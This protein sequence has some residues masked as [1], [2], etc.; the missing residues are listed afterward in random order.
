MPRANRRQFLSGSV[1][2]WATL[3]ASN[4]SAMQQAGVKQT[5]RA[6][7]ATSNITPF[8]GS[9]LAGNMTD[10]KAA[11]VH[12]EL[13]VRSLVLDDGANILAIAVADC[14]VMPRDIADAA[15][16][17]IQ[18]RTGI[19]AAHVL[20][21]AT[22]THSAP[23]T[24][25]LFQSIP[26]PA[27]TAWLTVRIADSVQLAHTRRRPAQIGWG[28]GKEDRL[29]F[30]RRYFMK[31]GTEWRDPFGRIDRVKTN[32]GAGNPDVV[33]PAGPT[34]PDVAVL[35]VE[36]L[37][38][39]PI[40]VLAS[41]ALHY[42]G[43]VGPRHVSADYFAMWGKS[44]ARLI[45]SGRPGVPLDG[46]VPIL[47]NACSGDVNN[48]DVL[49]PKRPKLPPYEHM[50][51]V[52]DALAAESY[53][54]WSG[55]QWTNWAPLRAAVEEVTI[56]TR[57][58]SSTE[59]A[60][61]QKI[62]E[63]AEGRALSGVREIYARETVMLHQGFDTEETLP[64]QAMSIGSLGI[65]ALPGEF[66]ASSGMA[67]KRESPAR[68]T[69]MISLANDYRGY[70]PPPESMEQGGYETWR[71]KSSHLEPKAEPKIVAAALRQLKA[72]RP[73]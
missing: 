20:I 60:E 66:F 51:K 44:L 27:Y 32:P 57:L 1:G 22:H 41:Y 47:A 54:V 37:D 58:P 39:Q 49:G 30:N 8:L 11:E 28:M 17:L 72:V 61:A 33:R 36:G 19:P 29:V 26:D 4:A 5:L 55:L 23:A 71:A 25:H 43:D 65:S 24:A 53:K 40:S 52:A 42:V 9:S 10:I 12:D 38:G 67:V 15:K 16:A 68:M 2:G 35:G 31:P 14:C 45:A 63:A 34:D 59:V 21:A 6:G 46:F 62:L 50:K 70:V 56:A 7:A 18:A 69:M 48:V 3:F 73:A 64:L 13:H